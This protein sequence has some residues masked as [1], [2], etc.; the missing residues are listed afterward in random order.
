M[1]GSPLAWMPL[2]GVMYCP[3]AELVPPVG[4]VGVGVRVGEVVGAGGGAPVV[5]VRGGG[6]SWRRGRCG[7]AAVGEAPRGRRVVAV[8]REVGLGGHRDA[9]VG[10]VVVGVLVGA[11]RALVLSSAGRRAER[12]RHGRYKARLIA[13]RRVDLGGCSVAR[14]LVGSDARLRSERAARKVALGAE[15][16]RGAL[17][18]AEA[19][20]SR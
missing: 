7:R 2:G 10:R 13:G 8:V 14:T 18:G 16:G 20:V 12:R 9:A 15:R 3:K 1:A 4:V 6:R 17:L 11:G 19:P 5:E